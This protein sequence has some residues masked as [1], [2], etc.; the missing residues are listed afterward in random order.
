MAELLGRSAIEEIRPIS[1]A[2]DVLAQI[3]L[4]MGCGVTWNL[5]QLYAFVRSIAA[6]HAL[7][8][9]HFD[10]VIA[11]LAGRYADSPVR[12]LRTRAVVDSVRNSFTTRA[13]TEFVLYQSGGTIPDR[14]YYHLRLADSKAVIGELDEEFVWERRLGD[15]FSLGTQTWRIH[16]I[17]HN[18][19][20]VGPADP[21]GPMIPSGRPRTRTGRPKPRSPCSISSTTVKRT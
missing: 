5:D 6:Y 15:Q 20:E 8:R 19:V 9:R 12:E 4:S 11:M 17:T 18:D 21:N 3:L 13:G 14:G 2:L 1:N 10:L 16:A 7:P